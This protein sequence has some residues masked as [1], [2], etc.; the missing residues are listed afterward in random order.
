MCR[1]DRH[2][3]PVQAS[4]GQLGRSMHAA[5][6][7]GDPVGMRVTCND[8]RRSVS[9]WAIGSTIAGLDALQVEQST[10]TPAGACAA[11]ES[12]VSPDAEAARASCS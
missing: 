5:K 2:A 10:S 9:T 8:R 11:A 1:G 12:P 6:A 4:A 3:S 7:A